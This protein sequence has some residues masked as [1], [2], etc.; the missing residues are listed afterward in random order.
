MNIRFRLNQGA[1]TAETVPVNPGTTL[2]QFLT[3][4]QLYDS[5]RYSWT[6]NRREVDNPETE[7]LQED[8]SVSVT[9]EK[10]PGASQH[11]QITVG[12]RYT[13]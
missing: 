4:K 1:G 2:A 12:A 7:I 6:V 11:F 5:S 3:A 10:V 13:K 8:D 9:P